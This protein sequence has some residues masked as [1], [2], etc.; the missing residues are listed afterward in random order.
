MQLIRADLLREVLHGVNRCGEWPYVSSF[1]Y[2]GGLIDMVCLGAM[3][4]YWHL[5]LYDFIKDA[6]GAELQQE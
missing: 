2:M 4:R 3:E 5:S 1:T 6:I